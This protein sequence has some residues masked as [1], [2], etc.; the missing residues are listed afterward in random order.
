MVGA[1]TR[2][3][4]S[5]TYLPIGGTPTHAGDRRHGRALM[6]IAFV[7]ALALGGCT[8][9]PE[10]GNET[11]IDPRI[12]EGARS[13]GA[14]ADQLAVLESGNVTFEQYQA[15]VDRTITCMRDAGIDVVGDAVT[16]TRGFPEIQ[17]SFATSS[18]GRTDE[19]T[20]AIADDCIDSHSKFVEAAYQNAPGALEAQELQFDTYRPAI[21]ECLRQNGVDI[22]D[23]APPHDIFSAAGPLWEDKAVDCVAESGFGG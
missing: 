1:V 7:A 12:L 13:G 4:P 19:Q 9:T 14:D 11:S 5:G 8:G 18:P 20:T 17:Y 6:G 15:A 2:A 3:Y 21:I 10:A 22:D 23:D 16:E